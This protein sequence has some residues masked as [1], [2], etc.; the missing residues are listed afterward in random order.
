MNIKDAFR[1]QSFLNEVFQQGIT[2]LSNKANTYVTTETHK[3]SAAK[4]DVQDE[5]KTV[6]QTV[7]FDPKDVIRCVTMAIDAKRALCDAILKA[8]ANAE[9]NLDAQVETNKMRRQLVTC[10]NGMLHMNAKPVTRTGIGYT[11]NVEGNQTRYEYDV[12]TTYAE[13]F[14]HD[15]VA[16]LLKE[17]RDMADAVSNE[18]DKTLITTDIDFQPPWNVNMSFKEIIEDIAKAAAT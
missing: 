16:T 5:V 2:F 6:E 12:E 17:Q 4:P 11:F 9:K 10:L 14:D 3:K 1:Y 15:E 8:K 13:R 7:D 18:I